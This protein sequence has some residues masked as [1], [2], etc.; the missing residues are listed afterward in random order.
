MY[1]PNGPIGSWS[2]QPTRSWYP[3]T[4]APIF[5]YPASRADGPVCP[6]SEVLSM[7]T[8]G[9]TVRIYA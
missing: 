5:P 8:D 4:E 1:G 7:T 3:L 6:M 9:L 2:G